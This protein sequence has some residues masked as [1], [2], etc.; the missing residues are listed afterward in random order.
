MR[1]CQDRDLNLDYRCEPSAL[2]LTY[3]VCSALKSEQWRGPKTTSSARSLCSLR[4]LQFRTPISSNPKCCASLN[5]LEAL[6]IARPQQSDWNYCPLW[7]CHTDQ[8]AAEPEIRWHSFWRPTGLCCLQ[9][10]R[11]QMSWEIRGLVSDRLWLL[12]TLIWLNIWTLNKLILQIHKFLYGN[13]Y[14]TSASCGMFGFTPFWLK[15]TPLI[16]VSFPRN[17]TL[18]S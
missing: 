4:A 5:I 11:H 17:D 7:F 13:F 6:N 3:P 16:A 15:T 9:I 2:P 8:L 14:H 1:T 18:T 10:F 12:P